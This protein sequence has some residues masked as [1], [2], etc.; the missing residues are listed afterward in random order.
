MSINIQIQLT[1]DQSI[2]YHIG[3]EPQPVPERW[4]S[5]AITEWLIMRE[6]AVA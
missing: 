5:D 1:D 4:V 6:E 2:S 3:G